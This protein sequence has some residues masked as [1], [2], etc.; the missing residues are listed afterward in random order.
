MSN[1]KSLLRATTAIALVLAPVIRTSNFAG[2][3]GFGGDTEHIKVTKEAHLEN[4]VG[5]FPSAIIR[6]AV[7]MMR[8]GRE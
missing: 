7:Q 3:L 8:W 4:G 1:G 2:F 6:V 5:I